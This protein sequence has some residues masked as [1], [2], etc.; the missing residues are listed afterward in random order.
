MLNAIARG[1]FETNYI[2]CES[3]Q[4]LFSV[5]DVKFDDILKM[6]WESYGFFFVFFLENKNGCERNLT[7]L[8]KDRG[9]A[10]G[11]NAHC[12]FDVVLRQHGIGIPSI[13]VVII[14]TNLVKM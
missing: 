13:P 1:E 8:S 7:G 9:V 6:T 3:K 11:G 14:C 12:R 4:C 10:S 2:S 5:H